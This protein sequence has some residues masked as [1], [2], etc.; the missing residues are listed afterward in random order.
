M[1]AATG[2]G[3]GG[4]ATVNQAVVPPEASGLRLD[5]YAAQL[6]G[7]VSRAMA[8]R[9]IE[10]GELTV[11]GHPGRPS[12]R[13][14]GGELIA[15][16]IPPPEPATAEPEDL[17]LDILYEDEDL[18]VIDKPRGMV[19]HPAAGNRRGTLVNA[20]LAHAGTLSGVG[21][22]ARPGIVH[23]LDKDTSG[24]MVVAKNDS[25]HLA[26][27]AQFKAHSIDRRYLA[28][29]KGH[30]P[31]PEGTVSGN[32]G[33]HPRHRKK[34]AVVQT[35]G[36]PAVTHWRV[37]EEFPGYTLIEARLETGRTH[38]IRVHLS[39]IGH[40]VAGDPV[41]GGKA[42][43]LNLQGQALHAAVLAFRHPRT[44]KKLAFR[45]VPPSDFQAA[46]TQLRSRQS[47]S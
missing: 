3:K 14:S 45:T 42:G 17:P 28:L 39:H 35:G 5:V 33:R 38:Q 31:T 25:A 34:M 22:V 1:A 30:L 6:P 27:A 36:K 19:V 44:G 23:R 11:N 8:Q 47:S 12:L 4:I 46:L 16:T 40:P 21:G 20:V 18:I 41:Y 9:L 43:E 15:Y 37:I 2:A 29:I 32:I 7:I 10:G 24:V 26:L 13:L